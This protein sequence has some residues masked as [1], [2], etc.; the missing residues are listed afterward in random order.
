VSKSGNRVVVLTADA[1]KIVLGTN[2]IDEMQPSNTS[3]MPEGLLDDLTLDEI[4]DLFAFLLELPDVE[5]AR[6]E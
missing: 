6:R 5:T 1:K 2:E 3:A 4:R